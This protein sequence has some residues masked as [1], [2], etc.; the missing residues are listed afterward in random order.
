MANSIRDLSLYKRVADLIR[1]FKNMKN[2]QQMGNDTRVI[3]ENST[4]QQYDFSITANSGGT[5]SVVKYMYFKPNS[6]QPVDG[7]LIFHITY[8]GSAPV[9]SNQF[10]TNLQDLR[11]INYNPSKVENGYTINAYNLMT[12][13]TIY[14]KAYYYTTDKGQLTIENSYRSLT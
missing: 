7:N 3:V 4:D 13:G 10:N 12:S 5:A 14:F 8:D 11:T 9:A 2:S 6:R 1:E